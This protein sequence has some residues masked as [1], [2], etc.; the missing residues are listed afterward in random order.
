ME[1]KRHAEKTGHVALSEIRDEAEDNTVRTC[2]TPG[3]TFM[4]Q[5]N[6]AATRHRHDTGHKGF[7]II[8]DY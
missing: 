5:G 7:S 1:G 3:C 4:G 8:P 6:A 2:D